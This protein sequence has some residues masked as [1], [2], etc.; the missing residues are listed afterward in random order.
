MTTPKDVPWAAG[1]L[2]ATL[3]VNKETSRTE[4]SAC[5]S[6]TAAAWRKLPT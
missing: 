6:M 3:T 5:C 2:E 1:K 4:L